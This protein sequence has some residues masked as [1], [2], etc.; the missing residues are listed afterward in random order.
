MNPAC[1]PIISENV[2]R[3]WRFYVIGH[4]LGHSSVESSLHALDKST[5]NR[6]RRREQ[7]LHYHEGCGLSILVTPPPSE[8]RRSN[9]SSVL[10]AKLAVPTDIRREAM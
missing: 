9:F 4:E 6:S 8:N 1:L 2:R 7:P 5:G 3:F 10:A